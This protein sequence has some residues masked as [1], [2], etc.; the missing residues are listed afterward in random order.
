MARL[1]LSTSITLAKIYSRR[2]LLVVVIAARKTLAAARLAMGFVA[3][4]FAAFFAALF[5]AA[6]LPNSV[7]E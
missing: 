5:A 1:D 6:L 3:A 7:S 2:F 4:S